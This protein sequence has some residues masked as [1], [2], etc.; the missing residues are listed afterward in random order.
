MPHLAP[1]SHLPGPCKCCCVLLPPLALL[2]SLCFLLH[3][4]AF[5]AALRLLAKVGESKA[6]SQLPAIN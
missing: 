3:P 1:P 4:L 5:F 2:R 6:L